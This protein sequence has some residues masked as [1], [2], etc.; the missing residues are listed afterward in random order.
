MSTLLCSTSGPPVA[1]LAG[2][3]YNPEVFVVADQLWLR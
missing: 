3:Q 1:R 2:Y